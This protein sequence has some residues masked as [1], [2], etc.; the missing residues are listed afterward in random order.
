M[1]QKGSAETNELE[2]YLGKAREVLDVLGV[3]AIPDHENPVW[4]AIAG[5]SPLSD[6]QISALV[7]SGEMT[8]AE[9]QDYRLSSTRGET[10]ASSLESLIW[11]G[12]SPRKSLILK[13]YVLCQTACLNQSGG[14]IGTGD[15]GTIRQRWYFSKDPAAMGF[16]FAAQALEQYLIR[17]ADVVLV[18]DAGERDRAQLSGAKRI[19][20]KNRWTKARAKDT[21]ETLGRTARI[22]IWPKAGW[23]RSYACLQSKIMADLVRDGLTY[24]QLWV[25]DASRKVKG[26]APLLTGFHGALLLEKEGLFEHFTNFCQA[27]GVPVLVAMSGANAFSSTEAVLND[28]FRT[29]DGHYRP[30]IDNPLHLFVISDHDYSGHVP[31]QEGAAAQ[32]RRYLAD[33]VI[34]HRIGI[35]PQQVRDAGRSVAQAGYEFDTNRNRATKEWADDE[36]VWVGETCFGIEVEA[37]EPAAYIEA[38]VEAIIEAVGGDEALRKRLLEMAEPDWNEVQREAQYVADRRS[39]L[40]KTLALLGD[41]AKEEQ[42]KRSEPM[43]E[44]I[45]TIMNSGWKDSPSVRQAI[46]GAVEDQAKAVTAD[47][48]K[49]H[50]QGGGWSAFR[51]V[52][53]GQA[54]A[55]LV[56]LLHEEFEWDIKDTASNIDAAPLADVLGQIVEMLTPFGLEVN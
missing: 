36:G 35:S 28:H 30:T 48:F 32:F 55:A 25:R 10:M 13:A 6:K 33:A 27:A 22:H 16:K 51:P 47:D 14:A 5:L 31:I 49:N 17:S 19:E 3:Q 50:V 41:W 9:A 52:S 38:L 26:Y 43:L 29:Y 37:L 21:E 45:E 24:N 11:I 12:S 44:T 23:G 53:A 7:S 2:Q 40:L 4:L 39:K 15:L 46:E 42:G 34:V 56:Q 20:Y 1:R 8:D 18:G 54:N